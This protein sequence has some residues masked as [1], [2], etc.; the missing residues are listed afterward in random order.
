MRSAWGWLGGGPS[1]A[2]SPVKADETPEEPCM[3][4]SR[5]MWELFVAN[6]ALV[7]AIS[8]DTAIAS[9]EDA[10]TERIDDLFAGLQR[11]KKDFG[12]ARKSSV[13]CDAGSIDI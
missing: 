13:W 4:T 7:A 10:F 1:T 6:R 3:F 12:Q 2:A 5:R 9:N 8:P 11:N